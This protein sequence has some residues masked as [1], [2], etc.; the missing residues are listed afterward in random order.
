[1]SNIW[2][3]KHLS[4]SICA[5]TTFLRECDS[6]PEVVLPELFVLR[7]HEKIEIFKKTLINC[8]LQKQHEAG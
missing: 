1:M 6:L 7:S 8:A 5:S 2:F 3:K 4:L